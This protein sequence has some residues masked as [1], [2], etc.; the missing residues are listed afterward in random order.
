MTQEKCHV[1]SGLMHRKVVTSQ[2]TGG[3]QY[4]VAEQSAP[5]TLG[6]ALH[7][8]DGADNVAEGDARVSGTD[9]TTYAGGAAA[10]ETVAAL[11]EADRKGAGSMLPRETVL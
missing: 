8:S 2:E 10:L 4:P 3:Q 1:P 5:S 9:G 11:A 6:P 7:W